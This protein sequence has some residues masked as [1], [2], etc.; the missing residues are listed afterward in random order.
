MPDRHSPLIYTYFWLN[1]SHL[2][3]LIFIFIKEANSART[4]N[5]PPMTG[6]RHRQ[7][8]ATQVGWGC[9]AAWS[10]PITTQR[11]GPKMPPP[12]QAYPRQ[13][14]SRKVPRR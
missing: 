4:G 13:S 10:S 3:L 6:I 14:T 12:V 7:V 1:I 9:R 8:P 2:S 5:T 11:H